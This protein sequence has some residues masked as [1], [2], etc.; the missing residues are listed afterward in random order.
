MQ[1]QRRMGAGA[2][3]DADT[4]W[5]TRRDRFITKRLIYKLMRKG[6]LHTFELLWAVTICSALFFSFPVRAQDKP[7]DI[8]IDQARRLFEEH[9]KNLEKLKQDQQSLETETQALDSERAN[10]QSRLIE[11]GRSAQA[12]EKKLTTLESNLERLVVEEGEIR[13]ALNESRQTIGQMLGVMQVMGREPPPVMVTKRSDALKMVRS[14]MVLSSFFPKFKEEADRLSK[15]LTDL[16]RV[17]AEGRDQQKRLADE[18][19]EFARLRTEINTLLAEK[20]EKLRGNFSRLEDL[21]VAASRHTRAV[22]DLSDLL[23]RLDTEVGQRSNLAAYE[24]EL[25][26]LGPIIELKPE[27]KQIAFVQPGRL[28]PS[29]P[30]EK[31]KGQLLLPVSGKKIKAFGTRDETGGKS[32]GISVETREEAQIVA[33]SDGWVIYAGQF[34]SYGQLLIIN[35]GGGYHILLAGMDQIYTSVGQFV[36]AGEPVAVM[37]KAAPQTSGGAQSRGPALYIEFRK[38]ARPVDPDPWWSQ[39]VKEG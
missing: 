25:K 11:A 39:G 9:Q 4:V 10:L 36:L 21:K 24:A 33:P 30:F 23:Q 5:Q 32:E 38:D 28:K 14:A 12:S 8:D 15:R 26:R 16:D 1:E 7:G 2:A 13:L 17:L 29:I 3:H 34:R 35:A 37:G 6:R 27:A 18:K 22:T 31:A 20:R 19:Q